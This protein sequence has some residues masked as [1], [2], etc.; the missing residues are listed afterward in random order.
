MSKIKT[1]FK[2]YAE[3]QKV[4][5]AFYRKHWLGNFIVVA[6][7][8]VLTFFASALYLKHK[9]KKENELVMATENTINE[10]RKE[11]A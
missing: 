10:S 8:W 1:Y 6:V 5:N 9:D 4:C 3:A 11:E 7:V 2:D